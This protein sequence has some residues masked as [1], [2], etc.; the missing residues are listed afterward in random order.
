MQGDLFRVKFDRAVVTI[1][2]I[3]DKVQRLHWNCTACE[4]PCEH[5]GAAF[6]LILE[7]KLALGLAAAPKER[8]P[9]E[10]LSEEQLVAQ[11]IAEREERARKEKFKLQSSNPARPWADYSVTSA[12]SG[13]TYQVTL[14]GRE[15]GTSYCSCP[16]FRT[17]TLGTCKHL[18]HV[19]R[20]IQPKF[21]AATLRRRSQRKKLT[22]QLVSGKGLALRVNSPPKLDEEVTRVLRG[23]LDCDLSDVHDLMKRLTK[24]ERL[25]AT[26]YYLPRRR[27]VH[28]AAVVSKSH[29]VAG[30]GDSAQ[31]HLASA[32]EIAVE[33]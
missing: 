10:S 28:P 21:P 17:N 25:G 15:P 6:A 33:D 23:A 29:R 18:L 7:E 11:A 24:L 5:A 8:V 2:L 30:L 9:I 13:K 3:A 1:T 32:A 27:G 16:D 20:K 31:S 14:R 19:L 4:V 12:A 22:V 26:R